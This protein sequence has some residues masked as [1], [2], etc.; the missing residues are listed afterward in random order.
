MN[1][2]WAQG[3]LGA[4]TFNPLL[5]FS[6][7]PQ[8]IQLLQSVPQ[9][10]QQL[11]Q[12]EYVRLQQLQQIQQLVQYVVHQLQFV[13]QPQ[14]AQSSLGAFSQPTLG[15]PYQSISSL[16]PGQWQASQLPVM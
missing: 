11:Q 9:Q 12:I 2:N 1:Q 7:T 4:Q 16:I 3:T 6:S 13:A 14:L 5:T 10:L 8:V 15:Q